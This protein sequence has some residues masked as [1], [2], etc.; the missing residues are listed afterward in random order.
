MCEVLNVSRA[1]YFKYIKHSMSSE[2]EVENCEL[3]LE[4][5]EIYNKSKGAYGSPRVWAE[6]VA[7]GRRIN[8]KRVQRLMK[9]NGIK[10]RIRRKFRFTTDSKKTREGIPDLVNRNF[11]ADEVNKISGQVT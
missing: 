1:G 10:A 2:R 11:Q 7:R 6:L 4:I 3:L 9:V 8:R 5:K